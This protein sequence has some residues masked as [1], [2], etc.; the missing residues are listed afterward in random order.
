M[1][2]PDGP[3]S[4]IVRLTDDDGPHPPL[5]GLHGT[6][7]ASGWTAEVRDLER[8]VHVSLLPPT[9]PPEVRGTAAELAVLAYYDGDLAA[10]AG[11]PVIERATPFRETVWRHMRQIPPGEA[12]SYGDLAAA[13]GYPRAAR[14]VGSTCAANA[15]ALFV[16]CHRVIHADGTPGAFGWRPELKLALLAREGTAGFT[17]G[18]GDVTR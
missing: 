15:C 9:L 6:V 7:V 13:A 2:T 10:P 5:P 8:P 11:V 12:W 14:A 16:P 1:T 4:A 17:S 18:P 3:F